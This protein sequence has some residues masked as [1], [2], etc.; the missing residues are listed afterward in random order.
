MPA[1]YETRHD[2]GDALPTHRHRT[3]YAAL[4]VEGSYEENSADGPL[5][6]RP[7]V[8]LLHPAYHAHGNRFERSGARVINLVLPARE[9][10]AQAQ[11][12]VVPDLREAM[13]IFR[14]APERFEELRAACPLDDELPAVPAWQRGV[15][16]ALATSDRPIADI[17]R[18]FGVSAEHASRALSLSYGMSPQAL[19][20]EFRWRRAL[21]LLATPAPLAEIAVDAGF[22]DQSHFTRIARAHA[23]LPP[24]ALRRHV[25]G[26]KCV[27]DATGPTALQ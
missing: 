18:E 3:A 15:V 4:V 19:R 27:Q 12:R 11:A 25:A 22:A 8:L 21:A 17:A 16:E 1:C 13:A 26:I 23:G 7:G 24:S 20:R 5:P 9:D 6:L 2:R 14:R 10:L